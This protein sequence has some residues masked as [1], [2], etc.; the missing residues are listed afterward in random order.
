MDHKTKIEKYQEMIK[1]VESFTANG[2]DKVSVMANVTAVMK[3]TF[4]ETFFWVGFYVGKDNVLLVGPLQGAPACVLIKYGKGVC[5]T[6]WER[7]ET[8]IVPDVEL[9]DGHIACS[10][11]SRSEIVVPVMLDGE[12]VAEIDIDSTDVASFDETD[13]T[14]LE[15]VAAMV[16]PYFGQDS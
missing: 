8:L 13:R 3:M 16:A 12:V 5:G 14:Y 10:S 6:A 7:R 1:L 2:G 11:L 4:P 9:F 15:E